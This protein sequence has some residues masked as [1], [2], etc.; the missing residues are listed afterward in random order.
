MHVKGG[1]ARMDVMKEGKEEGRERGKSI[2]GNGRGRS[3]RMFK[4]TISGV[5]RKDSL[6]VTPTK[7]QR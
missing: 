3:H 2:K 5:F 1:R 4:G 7:D 6:G